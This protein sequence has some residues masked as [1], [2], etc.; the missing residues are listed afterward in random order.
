MA[1]QQPLQG[2]TAVITGASAGIGA[3]TARSLASEGANLVLAAR[4]ETRLTDLASELQE[5][6]VEAVAVPTD[7][8]DDDAVDAL[9]TSSAP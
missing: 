1:E 6:G 2:K 8:R 3:E 9:M 5:M 7:I 4:S